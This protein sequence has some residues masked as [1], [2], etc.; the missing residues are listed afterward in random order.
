LIKILHKHS[1]LVF[2]VAGLAAL[3]LANPAAQS[4]FSLC[5]LKLSGIKWCPGCGIG[6]AIMHLLHGRIAYSL[7][8]HWLGIPA[9][10]VIIYRIYC[11]SIKQM[12]IF[13]K[14]KLVKHGF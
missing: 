5:L 6:H 11:L 4:H 3:A 13:R 1:E 7:D 9:L 2:W 14:L 8:T 12:F 10:A